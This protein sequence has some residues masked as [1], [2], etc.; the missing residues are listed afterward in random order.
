MIQPVIA[1]TYIHLEEP[2]RRIFAYRRRAVF[3]TSTH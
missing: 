3:S 1:I 2:V